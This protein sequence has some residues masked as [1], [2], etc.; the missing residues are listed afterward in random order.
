MR[1]KHLNLLFVSINI[2]YL[3]I[4]Q[5]H[6][7]NHLSVFHCFLVK[8]KILIRG[9]YEGLGV[10]YNSLLLINPADNLLGLGYDNFA[11]IYHTNFLNQ[12]LVDIFDEICISMSALICLT[13]L[14]L[15]QQREFQ[16]LA[17]V[18]FLGLRW[19]A[20]VACHRRL[21]PFPLL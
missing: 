1:F 8:L 7:W 3:V 20:S 17:E 10:L 2:K 11:T 13:K 16:F 4:M 12:S 21:R 6:G 5:C 15:E 19:P 9:F 14:D 18:V